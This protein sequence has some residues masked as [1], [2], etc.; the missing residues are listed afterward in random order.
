MKKCFLFLAEGF[1]DIEAVA[2]VDVLRRGGVEVKTVSITDE[3]Q[4]KSAHD[5]VVMADQIFEEVKWEEAACLICPGGLPGARYLSE[6]E[7]LLQRLQ[8]QY[9]AGRYIAA[10]C[11]SP[12][13]VFSKLNLKAPF[14]MTCYPG[15]E[16]ILPTSFRVSE[17]GVVVDGKTITA[18]GPAYAVPF[19]LMILEQLVSPEVAHEVAAGMLL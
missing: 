11:A 18:K 2:V 12:A 16:D 17:R 5:I 7:P 10:I 15:F 6:F 9:D 8:Q 3:K 4:V 14:Q 19:G 1:E 13:M